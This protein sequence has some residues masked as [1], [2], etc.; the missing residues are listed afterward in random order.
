MEKYLLNIIDV[1][2][3]LTH[4]GGIELNQD[5]LHDIYYT[6]GS[7]TSATKEAIRQLNKIKGAK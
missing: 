7:L 4:Q 6:V 3:N 2:F 1:I 5:E